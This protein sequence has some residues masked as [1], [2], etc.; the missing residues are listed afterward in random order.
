MRLGQ[1]AESD[2]E[3]IRRKGSNGNMLFFIHY[4]TVVNLIGKDDKL[5]FSCN[6]DDLLKHFFRIQCP[7]RIVW[8]DDNDGFRTV[9]DLSADIFNVR[10][11]F[12][13]FIANVMYSLSAGKCGTGGPQRIIRG[14][15]QDLI[16]VV[17]ECRHER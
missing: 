15:D 9:G 17:Q 5:M 3:E 4:E 2:A 7:G 8:V 14:R 16:S 11:P 1:T 13:L 10:I 12:R 6:I